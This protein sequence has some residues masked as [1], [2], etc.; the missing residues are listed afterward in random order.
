MDDPNNTT[1]TLV[2]AEEELLT[3]TVSD[4]AMEAAA[5][6]RGG[7]ESARTAPICCGTLMICF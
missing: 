3:Y 7:A 1:S 6:M 4:D 5:D 2:E